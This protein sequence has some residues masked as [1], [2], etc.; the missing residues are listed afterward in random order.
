MLP[1]EKQSKV[2]T[3]VNWLFDERYSEIKN[4]YG[5]FYAPGGTYNTKSII[6]KL[7]LPN[8][9]N[10]VMENSEVQG[11]LFKVY[12]MSRFNTAKKTEWYSLAR[13][14]L[15]QYAT[16]TGRYKF[17]KIMVTDKKDKYFTDGGHMNLGESRKL[18]LCDEI[19]STY[20]MWLIEN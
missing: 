13:M 19:L 16:K 18:K 2:D 20:W 3:I 1:S 8:L 10:V 6:I 7:H 12:L 17:P 9:K 15:N 11:L 4:R 14:Y 5:Y